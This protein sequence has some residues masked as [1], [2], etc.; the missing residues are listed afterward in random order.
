MAALVLRQTRELAL[1]LARYWR[2]SGLP[3]AHAGRD[4]A[5]RRL[6]GFVLR[7]VGT[8]FFVQV[9]FMMGWTTRNLHLGDQRLCD[10]WLVTSLLGWGVFFGVALHT[11]RVRAVV[12]PLSAPFL[13]TL[14]LSETSR[15][16]AHLV[17]NVLAYLFAVGV[18]F[19]AAREVGLLHAILFGV[20]V[21]FTATL[22]GSAAVRLLRTAVPPMRVASVS[23]VLMFAQL[24]VLFSMQAA[25]L[26]LSW[27]PTRAVA[28]AMLPIADALR[29]PSRMPVSLFCLACLSTAACLVIALTVRIGYDRIDAVP[30]T[31]YARTAVGALSLAHTE[32]LVS[33][34]E[35]GARASWIV[36]VYSLLAG[37]GLC[38]GAWYFPQLTTSKEFASPVLRFASG[39]VLVMAGS[40]AMA[41]ASRLAERDAIARPFLAPLPIAPS[42]L[43]SGKASAVRRRSLILCTPFLLALVAPGGASWHIEVAWRLV[44]TFIAIAVVSDAAVSVAFLTNGLGAPA[45]AAPGPASTFQLE[46][47]LLML[48]LFGVATAPNPWSAAVSIGCLVLLR[49]EGRRAALACVQWIDDAEDFDRVPQV[50]RALVVLASFQAWQMLAAQLLALTPISPAFAI[51]IAYALSAVALVALTAYERRRM[52]PIAF[53]PARTWLVA[54]GPIG[55]LASGGLALGYQWC[56]RHFGVE[57]PEVVAAVA[58]RWALGAAIV[59]AAPFAEEFFFRGWLQDAVEREHPRRGRWFALAATAFAFAAVHP[60]VSFVPVVVLGVVT[61]TLYTTSRS[62][63]PGIIAHAAHNLLVLALA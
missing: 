34:R 17:Q 48:P 25:P 36:F 12:P 27:A 50:W 31:R 51:A 23:R 32:T 62:V 55:G 42:D 29:H 18:V 6:S 58:G 61:G 9:G 20:P 8:L 19:G 15:E 35:P 57:L 4:G 53:R 28:R 13:D 45:R 47:L 21:A 33:S 60:P 16:I 43:L 49:A 10:G 46:T 52:A 26:L 56:L 30:T 5:S 44:A 7:V 24:P 63:T 54:L 40:T 37:G 39:V 1:L 14:P 3:R 59:V 2:R 41:R 11:P 38:A 22:I